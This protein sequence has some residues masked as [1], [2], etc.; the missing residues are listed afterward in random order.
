MKKYAYMLYINNSVT[1]KEEKN[2][3][4]GKM[5]SIRDFHINQSMLDSAKQ[6]F[7]FSL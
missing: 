5:Y 6:V 1:D 4:C 7:M 3:L 2:S